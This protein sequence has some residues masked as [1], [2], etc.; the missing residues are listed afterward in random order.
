MNGSSWGGSEEL[1]Y[2][3]ALDTA[4]RGIETAVCCFDWPGKEIRM[5]KLKD[6]GCKLYMLPGKKITNA[7]PLLGKLKLSKAVSG[8]PFEK[9]DKV[10]VSQGGWKDITSAPFKNLYKRLKEYVLIYHNY[11][12]TDKFPPAKFLL[13]QKWADKA[14]KN[15]GDTPK[16]FETLEKAYSLTIP[17][18]EKLFNPLTFDTPQTI[19]PYPEAD[20]NKYILSVFAA[21]D[22]GRKAQDVLIKALSA[23]AWR[24]RNWELRLYGEG[25]DKTLLQDLI[26]QQEM[27]SKI[28]LKG[29]A[30]DYKEAIRQSHLVLQV[31]NIDAMPITVMDSLAM[32]RPVVVSNVGDMPSWV[33]ENLNGWITKAVS[34]EA[35]Q[36]TLELAWAHQHNWPEMGKKSFAI[37]Q[38][39][40]PANPIEYFLNQTGIIS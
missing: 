30:T 15:L 39:D 2:Q 28:F 12:D 26:A 4:R 27:Q 9:Y 36:E 25:K 35:I 1:W 37:F 13:L 3:A 33:Q 34:V 14:F 24:N 16:I 8:V 10:I 38:R 18:H 20:N 22:T 5:N 31:T 21:L 6:A 23:S 11:N 7:Q 17:N 19:T 32:A 29:N 40:F